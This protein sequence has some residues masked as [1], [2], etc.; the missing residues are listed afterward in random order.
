MYGKA[1]QRF[2]Y[3]VDTVTRR[4]YRM[5]F[6]KHVPWYDVLKLV[7]HHFGNQHFR[8]LMALFRREEALVR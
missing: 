1:N 7:I 5:R 4:S 6:E 3:H 8:G 2:F